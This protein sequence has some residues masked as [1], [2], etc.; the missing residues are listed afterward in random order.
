MR[1]L[2]SILCREWNSETALLNILVFARVV[3]V[4]N[5]TC[6]IPWTILGTFVMDHS[7]IYVR[8][9]TNDHPPMPIQDDALSIHLPK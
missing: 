5:I 1:V 9:R 3:I 6:Y 2:C 4:A 8:S 7:N